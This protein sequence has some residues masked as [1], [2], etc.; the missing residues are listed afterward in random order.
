MV[1]EDHSG[2]FIETENMGKNVHFRKCHSQ[3]VGIDRLT[4]NQL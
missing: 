1:T 2:R 4:D 3:P